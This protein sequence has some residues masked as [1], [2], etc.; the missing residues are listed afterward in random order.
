[1][2]AK[3]TS[4]SFDCDHDEALHNLGLA[5]LKAIA[6]ADICEGEPFVGPRTTN[7]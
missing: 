1:M 7:K 4:I 3:R 5:E 6:F 2:A